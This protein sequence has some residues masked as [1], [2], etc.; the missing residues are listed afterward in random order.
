MIQISELH[1]PTQRGWQRLCFA[2]GQAGAV[3]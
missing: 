2:D 1:I 3:E